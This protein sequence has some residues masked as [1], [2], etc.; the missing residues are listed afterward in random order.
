MRSRLIMAT[1]V[2]L[3]GVLCASVAFAAVP[4]AV[5]VTAAPW[6]AGT[7]AKDTLGEVRT[8]GLAVGGVTVLPSGQPMAAGLPEQVAVNREAGIRIEMSQGRNWDAYGDLFASST[9]LSSPYLSGASTFASAKFAL[10][11]D[12]SVEFSHANLDLAA[13]DATPSGTPTADL[14]RRL[15]GGVQ[16][17]GTTSANL[18]WNFADW[19]GL[20]LMASHSAG[21][22]SLLGSI[23]PTGTAGLAESATLGISA[24]V[25]FGEGWVT[26]V[27]YNE[28]V[29]Q[30]DLNHAQLNARL[31][32]IRSQAYAL[33]V[34]K[35][36][37][38]GDDA[39]GIAVS[40]PLQIYGTSNLASINPNLAQ[41]RESDVELG[42][43]TTFLDG[44]LA[45]QANA[46]YQ[47]NAAGAKGQN[48]VTGV[49]RAK[50]NF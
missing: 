25:G 27:A 18:N 23:V 35:Q 12:V 34:A 6:S 43:V 10:S 15:G 24:R 1:P 3:T 11:R 44:T 28:G 48:A 30:L 13:F 21:D 14:A 16:L 32:P 19:G 7:I 46:A 8:V 45:L 41:A 31:D 5:M 36:G 39:L 42:Y 50:L 2:V 40:R 9:A 37:L 17:I 33:G 49:A 20:A 29:T 4:G 22:G 47:V 26:T 38:F